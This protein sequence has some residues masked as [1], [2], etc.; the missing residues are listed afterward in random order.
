MYSQKD[1][2]IYILK[3]FS[4]LS[5][6]QFL[7]IGANNGVV[8]SNTRRLVELGWSG[9]CVE[10]DPSAF[11]SLIENNLDRSNII[12]INAGL[13]E[14][15]GL[16]EFYAFKDSLL[17]SFNL[18]QREIWKNAPPTRNY[19]VNQ[20]TWDQLLKLVSYNF[21]FVNIDAE[22]MSCDLLKV[23][24]FKKLQPQ[25]ICVEHDGDVFKIDAIFQ[26]VGYKEYHTNDLNCLYVRKD[27]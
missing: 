4:K 16:K 27:I 11:K 25:M 23:L 20:I 26:S 7:D 19:Y 14:T 8:F 22:G 13:G 10:P 2:E 6:G 12:L 5:K 18:E 24:P 9:V 3:Y 15:S 21:D 17:S 1:D